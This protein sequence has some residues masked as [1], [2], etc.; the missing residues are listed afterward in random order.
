VNLREGVTFHEVNGI[1]YAVREFSAD[2]AALAEPKRTVLLLHG[3]LDSGATWD[4]VAPHLVAAGYQVFAPDFRG[5][6]ESGRIPK[7]GYYYFADYIA[8]VSGLVDA[9]APTDLSVVGHSMGGGVASL[10]TGVFPDRVRRLAI[11]EGLGP[12]NDPPGLAVARTRRW[13]ADLGRI[14]RSPRPLAGIEDAIA[15]LAAAH[16]RVDHEIIASRAPRLTRT[17]ESGRL[18]WAYD[19]LHRT[20][21]PTPFSADAYASFLREITCPT[22]FVGGGPQGWHPPDEA[23]R[24]AHLRDLRCVDLP[25]AGHMMHWTAPAELAAAL[26]EHLK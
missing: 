7:G 8:D 11:L 15:R 14:E 23:E 13:L 6:G 3:F 17:D 22:L 24:L 19:P 21:S 12:M 26:L 16:P 1:R 4:L 9:L 5:F 2:G 25:D 10:F 20:T 18:T